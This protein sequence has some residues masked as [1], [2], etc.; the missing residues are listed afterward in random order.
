MLVIGCVKR[1]NTKD[2]HVVVFFLHYK[3][4]SIT[5]RTL[6]EPPVYH[7]LT[8]TN[9][10]Q[11]Q[12]YIDKRFYQLKDQTNGGLLVTLPWWIRH[13]PDTDLEEFR[14]N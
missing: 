11:S 13:G 6:V 9:Q 12:Y 5:K 10:V 14:G 2:F 1:Y 8:S 7:G 4:F 3:L